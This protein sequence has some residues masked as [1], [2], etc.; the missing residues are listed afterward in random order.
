[1]FDRGIP[2]VFGYIEEG[3]YPI[4]ACYIEAHEGC[5]YQKNV[6]VTSPGGGRFLRTDSDRPQSFQQSVRLYR[7]ICRVY[8]RL[9]YM[10][11][12]LPKSSVNE[13]VR[14]LLKYITKSKPSP[15]QVL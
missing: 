7:S 12:E 3:M 14:Y 4:S 5:W 13:R 10:L 15:F 2:D 8:E 9:G 6:I 1:F 11:H